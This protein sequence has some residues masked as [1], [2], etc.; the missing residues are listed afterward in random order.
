V[1]SLLA[2][3]LAVDPQLQAALDGASAIPGARVEL[4]SWKGPASCQGHF[5]V[6]APIE[7]SGR[8]PV[9]VR[10]AR[11]DDW[12]WAMVTLSSPSAVA[13]REVK[14]GEPLS[15]SWTLET[16]EVRRGVRPI[17]SIDASATATRPLHKGQAIVAELLRAG[18]PPGTPITARASAGG[19][20]VEE[21]GTITPCSG[22]KVCATLAT[23]RRV[24]GQMQDG[25][26]ELALD[27]FASA[28][29]RP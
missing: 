23:G 21:R 18:P 14:A 15:G 20:V 11:C 10:G 2:L 19:I 4:L 24:T 27:T 26:L 17:T 25:V 28:G 12:G 22:D 5:A 9:R 16:L 1:L 8:V 6:L 13:T 29:G 3:I 7:A